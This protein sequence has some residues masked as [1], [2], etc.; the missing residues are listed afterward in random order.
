MLFNLK[1]PPKSLTK[2]IS[3]KPQSLI[4]RI[5][6]SFNIYKLLFIN[7]LKNLLKVTLYLRIVKKS[8]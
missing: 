1:K 6:L 8:S 3:T 7:V 2:I 4:L 5:F